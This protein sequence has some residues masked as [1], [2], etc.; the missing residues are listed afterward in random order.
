[1]L[2][3]LRVVAG[4]ALGFPSGLAG[5][6]VVVL[7]RPAAPWFAG[8]ERRRIGA[9]LGIDSA[10]PTRPQAVRYL[11][12]RAAVGTFGGVVLA[13]LFYGLAMTVPV[14]HRLAANGLDGVDWGEDLS[15]ALWTAL[16]GGVLLYIEVQGIIGVVALEAKVARRF[17]GPSEAEVLRRRIDE[18]ATSR[19]GIVAA[20]DAERRRI[21]RDL[22]DG[23]QQRLV[24]LG[25]L[26]G[27]ARRNPDH[28]DD[29]L[30]QAHDES[31]H[32]LEDLREVAWRVYP[33]ALDS[34]GLA[35]ALEAVADRSAIPVRIRCERFD[36]PARVETAVYFVV[37]EAVTNAAKH[38]GATMIRV[39]I[40]GG[41]G[42]VRVRVE[43]D[44]V[45]G[46][47]PAGGG[48]AG[49]ARRVS[50]LD[51]RF[52]VRSPAGG[53]TVITAEVPCG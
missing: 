37:S 14:A 47:D 26:L 28:A 8:L 4:L 49:L 45:G 31:R 19:A 10:E 11:A 29:L 18:L 53:P 48:L 33:A 36:A 12:V 1:M 9:F 2:R 3:G 13:W 20:V 17:L 7:A 15:A 43:D 30:R 42:E 21:E 40:G 38:S 44:G 32:V 34:L 41:G 25:M 24:A 50:A 23:V 5:L 39:D 22:H 46:A 35:E 27:R 16:V 6:L 52:A 51:G